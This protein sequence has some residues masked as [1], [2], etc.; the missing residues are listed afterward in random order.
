MAEVLAVPGRVWQQAWP[1]I[2]MRKE[3]EWLSWK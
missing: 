2:V 1:S 3:T